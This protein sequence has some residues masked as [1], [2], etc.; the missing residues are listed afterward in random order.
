MKYLVITLLGLSSL[1]GVVLADAPIVNAEAKEGVV[2]DQYIVV[3]K[4][5]AKLSASDRKKHEDDITRLSKNKKKAGISQSFN[6]TGFQGYNVEIDQ[7]DLAAITKF[8]AISYLEK[9]TI[10]QTV[11]PSLPTPGSIDTSK[12]NSATL[13]K[14]ALVSAYGYNW[15]DIRI[16]HKTKAAF[17][18]STSYIYDNTAGV[19]TWIYVVDTGVLINHQEVVGRATWGANFIAG[20]P[21]TDQHG[22]GTHVAGTAAGRY[23]GV[24]NRANI[25]AV[26]VLDATGRGP[27]TGVIS[28]LQWAANN[29]IANGRATKSVVNMSLGGPLSSA[30]N[31]MVQAVTN[32]GVTVVVAAGNDAKSATLY[33]PASAP[34]AI[35]VGASDKTDKWAYFSNFGSPVDIIAPGVGILSSYFTSPTSYVYMDGTSQ[36]TPHVAGLVAYFMAKDGVR[37]PVQ[38]LTKLKQWASSNLISSVPA[39]TV[40]TLAYNG[41]GY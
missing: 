35:T 7:A 40:N 15:G 2:P 29:A 31:Q 20:S 30:M 33:S 23:V 25:V 17:L 8:D 36:A 5:N 21:N 28:G 14:R 26:K 12:Y 37:G 3:Y 32:A 18:A 9:V 16:S 10:V 34:S 4:D 38:S 19:G 39:G 1:A 11:L 22:H 13:G 41:D 6:I 27:T 24:A